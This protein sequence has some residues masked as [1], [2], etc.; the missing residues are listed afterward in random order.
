MANIET[1]SVYIIVNFL[2]SAL[3]IK[4]KEAA[5]VTGPTNKKTK[6]APGLNPF[7]ISAIAIEDVEQLYI[8]TPTLR[9]FY[10]QIQR[11]AIIKPRMK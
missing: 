8:G 5:L 6:A 3:P 7:K 10:C 2:P 9:F 4:V 11:E 1:V